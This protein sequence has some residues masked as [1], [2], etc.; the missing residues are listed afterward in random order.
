VCD[1]GWRP[2]RQRQRVCLSQGIRRIRV[3]DASTIDLRSCSLTCTSFIYRPAMDFLRQPSVAY[4]E[5]DSPQNIQNT[6]SFSDRHFRHIDFHS[7]ISS[8]ENTAL[9][10]PCLLS[11]FFAIYRSVCIF[12]VERNGI[13]LHY[14]AGGSGE[15]IKLNT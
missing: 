1:E 10:N 9:R 15:C 12:C 11:R 14:K 2:H 3:V 7:S 8:S 5:S 6:K 13:S 4:R